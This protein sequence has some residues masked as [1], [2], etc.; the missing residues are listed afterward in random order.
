[1]DE[2]GSE[3]AALT[4]IVLDIRTARVPQVV[5]VDRRV[6]INARSNHLMCSFVFL[7]LLDI[8]Y[9]MTSPQTILVLHL[10]QGAR[11]ALVH[12]QDSRPL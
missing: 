12:G 11:R 1:M 9:A 10:R 4:G 3:A 7:L 5:T 8:Y 6:I 2:E